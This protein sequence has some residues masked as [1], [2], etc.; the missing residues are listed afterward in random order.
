[1][2]IK[3]DTTIFIFLFV[4]LSIIQYPSY[5]KTIYVDDDAAGANNGSSWENAHNDLQD[6]IA[7]AR[8]GDEI[9]VAQ[10][11]YTPLRRFILTNG[12]AILGG[13]AGFGAS[14]PNSRDIEKFKTI[15]SGRLDDVL[16]SDNVI[17]SE[18]TDS[19]TVLDGFTITGGHSTGIVRNGGDC[20]GGGGIYNKGG[21]PTILN[22]IITTNEGS[23]RGG[24]MANVG[25]GSPA[26]INC[27][28]ERNYS[29]SNGGGIYNRN[30]NLTLV[31]CRFINNF[32]DGFGGGIYN[33]D[34]AMNLSN[35]TFINNSSLIDGGG[36][37]NGYSAHLVLKGCSFI[38]NLAG[39]RGGGLASEEMLA[40]IENCIFSGN[41]ARELGGGII[42]GRLRNC[43]LTGN[44]APCNSAAGSTFLI[45]CIV[46]GNLKGDSIKCPWSV[47]ALYCCLESSVAYANGVGSIFVD[48][49]FVQPGYWDPNGTPEDSNDDFWVDGD[50]H[51]KSQA[52]R[53]DPKTQ[54][55][56]MDDVTSPCIDA[57]NPKSPIGHEP[58]PN[59]GR[60]NMGA[61]GGTAEASKSYFGKP[62]CETIIAGDINGD[63]VVNF[64]DF[65][66][67][68][69]H[70]LED[71]APNP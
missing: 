48:P 43:T 55:W 71:N 58:F 61:Y 54:A 59:G 7:V 21:S 30:S 53:W 62:P 63:C 49:C 57:G 39:N 2:H 6:A 9:K 4:F 32:S 29:F 36:I 10:G 3:I 47:G 42:G 60:I 20:C 45:N 65:K 17:W 25:G 24:G 70:W 64:T 23:L 33:D 31:D 56:T 27:I 18:N 1:M 50:Y 38:S 40:S 13:Y 51:L 15:L 26:L 28:F 35:C 11:T 67:M 16:W 68:A 22:C 19:T 41:I 34:G 37:Y 69:Y 52:G 12:V 8:I 44:K 5:S 66:L 14:D 46:W